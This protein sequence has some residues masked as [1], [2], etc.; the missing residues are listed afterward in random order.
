M[1]V[2]LD[3]SLPTSSSPRPPLPPTP[4]VNQREEA[5]MHSTIRQ[6]NMATLS[7]ARTHRVRAYCSPSVTRLQC[8]LKLISA[9]LE[10]LYV[11]KYASWYYTADLYNRSYWESLHCLSFVSTD[12]Q[13]SIFSVWQSNCHWKMS[14]DTDWKSLTSAFITYW[15]YATLE[16]FT[17]IYKKN[18]VQTTHTTYNWW[19][20]FKELK[21]VFLGG[22]LTFFHQEKQNFST[23]LLVI[24]INIKKKIKYF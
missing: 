4:T 16:M 18:I 1:S 3:T 15:T 19:I 13:F 7:Y 6:P 11:V 21:S 20:L 9:I 10:R 14:W 22:T 8:A 24:H 12:C 5:A 17:Y 2:W 23:P